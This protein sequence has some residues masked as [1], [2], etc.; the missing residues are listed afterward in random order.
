LEKRRGEM[1][2][3]NSTNDRE[4]EASIPGER[5]GSK[6][7]H[8]ADELRI[9]SLSVPPSSVPIASPVTS[10]RKIPLKPKRQKLPTQAIQLDMLNKLKKLTPFDKEQEHEFLAEMYKFRGSYAAR[11]DDEDWEEEERD[12]GRG[13]MDD[14]RMSEETLHPNRNGKGTSRSSRFSV[15]RRSSVTPNSNSMEVFALKKGQK[16][17]KIQYS[18]PRSQ[19]LIPKQ[20]GLWDTMIAILVVL[21]VIFLPYILAF[22]PDLGE[23]F[24]YADTS[25]DILFS[26]D[27]IIQFNTAYKIKLDSYDEDSVI[28]RNT[29]F[30]KGVV[31]TSKEKEV[32]LILYETRR[33]YVALNYCKGWFIVDLLAILP[34]F[35]E[36]GLHL[37]GDSYSGGATGSLSLAKTLRVPRLLRLASLSGFPLLN[38]FQEL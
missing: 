11:I 10:T 4:G 26:L 19:I 1:T 31:T 20:L 32:T 16:L 25:I 18:N 12:D 2:P 28:Y 3:A 23:G 14:G 27:L 24:G 30:S 35:I 22:D 13:S 8:A 38:G 7:G 29:G 9:P 37:I 33:K 15:R 34:L 21:Q 17:E 36:G 5:V 6:T